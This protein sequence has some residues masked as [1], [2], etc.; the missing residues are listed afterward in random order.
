MLLALCLFIFSH[1]MNINRVYAAQDKKQS[2]IVQ[3]Q[4][5]N[6]KQNNKDNA[7]INLGK[8][9]LLHVDL[10][11]SD[12][13]MLFN[14]HDS[15]TYDLRN[16]FDKTSVF[17]QIN[18]SFS[19][20][21]V[22]INLLGYNKLYVKQ[23]FDLIA[24][25]SN[26]VSIDYKLIDNKISFAT[27]PISDSLKWQFNINYNKSV[28]SKYNHLT[29]NIK[30]QN[31]SDNFIANAGLNI[32]K[33]D[34]SKRFINSSLLLQHNGD[35]NSSIAKNNYNL[36]VFA[37]EVSVNYS[38][39]DVVKSP[40]GLLA[41]IFMTASSDFDYDISLKNNI[42][43]TYSNTYNKKSYKFYDFDYDIN[44][45]KKLVIDLLSENLGFDFHVGHKYKLAYYDDGLFANLIDDSAL[46]T[47]ITQSRQS[48]AHYNTTYFNID[49]ANRY[50][51]IKN[52]IGLK[53]FNQDMQYQNWRYGN[54][55]NQDSVNKIA[56][57]NNSLNIV[58][59]DASM[60]LNGHVIA[61]NNSN[62]DLQLLGYR[63]S[64]AQLNHSTIELARYNIVNSIKEGA[65]ISLNY[66]YIDKY[67][68]INLHSGFNISL[69]NSLLFFNKKYNDSDILNLNQFSS[70]KFNDGAIHANHKYLANK[71]ILSANYTFNHQLHTLNLL[72]FFQWNI[73]NQDLI[74]NKIIN[75]NYLAKAYLPDTKLY[76]WL[77]QQYEYNGLGI[78]NSFRFIQLQS[79]LTQKLSNSYLY[80]SSLKLYYIYANNNPSNLAK[81]KFTL[82]IG[83]IG[84]ITNVSN[85]CSIDYLF[86]D[87]LDNLSAN[88]GKI[89]KNIF[90][91]FGVQMNF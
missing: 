66:N 81:I 23:I 57:T 45:G 59:L 2:V 36:L 69:N 54:K 32:N 64:T 43:F 4:N 18:K 28:N 90:L 48:F 34:A 62:L 38:L 22:E 13:N 91:S 35:Y 15:A 24:A 30:Y 77:S 86:N 46:A 3:Q 53:I 9:V 40:S 33:Y 74:D 11:K 31:N 67:N 65:Q 27:L 72:N 76:A 44:L 16:N 21:N 61:V 60:L 14:K 83:G 63:K 78:G 75:I 50:L 39:D 17:N 68:Y 56:W 82:Q 80:N 70:I 84:N 37:N 6:N 5:K 25:S 29:S 55:F 52:Y 10:S 71:L 51:D 88:Y 85:I 47:S 8:D 58:N 7:S 42:S 73:N 20:Q 87:Y 41:G 19:L 49:I 89:K 12:N 79:G 1:L 26:I